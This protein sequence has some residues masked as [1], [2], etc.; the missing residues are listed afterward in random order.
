MAEELGVLPTAVSNAVG[1][2]TFPPAWYF[3]CKRLAEDIG[4][5]CP[6]VL[7]GQRPLDSSHM[8]NLDSG[9]N[10]SKHGD[11]GEKS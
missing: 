6:R 8:V 1:R 5:A 10:K 3:T 11:A 2:S 9:V 7:F 4:I